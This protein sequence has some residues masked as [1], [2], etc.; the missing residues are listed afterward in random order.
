MPYSE[1]KLLLQKWSQARNA[2]ALLYV[3]GNRPGLE[4]QIHPEVLDFFT[5]HLDGVG[6]VKTISLFLHTRGGSTLAAWSLVNLLRQ[7]TERLEIVVPAKAHSAGT[8]MCLGA[9]A[10]MMTRQ[11][12]LGPI[13]PSVNGPLNPEI[14]GAPP[15]QRAPVSVEAI[16]GYFAFAKNEIGLSSEEARLGCAPIAVRPRSPACVGRRISESVADPDAGST[17]DQE[18]TLRRGANRKGA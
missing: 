10:I 1:R 7:F 2:M 6:T 18:T 15:Q 11:A 16:N 13:D 8:L 12:T 3:T 14:P 4:T 5:Q 17:T 9:D